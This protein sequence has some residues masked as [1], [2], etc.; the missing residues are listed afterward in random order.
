MTSFRKSLVILL[1]MLRGCRKALFG[2]TKAARMSV[3]GRMH[4]DGPQTLAST[5]AIFLPTRITL[6]RTALASASSTSTRI[7]Y[8]PSVTSS[9]GNGRIG[10]PPSVIP[11]SDQVILDTHRTMGD[12]AGESFEAINRNGGRTP[13]F[14][15]LSY[16]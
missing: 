16:L 3:L 10:T 11:P 12:E 9:C 13:P 6:R 15:S 14:S 2:L 4:I 8:Q 7:R 5:T 1:R